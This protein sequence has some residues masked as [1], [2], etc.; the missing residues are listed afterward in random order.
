MARV[1]S[2]TITYV[3]ETPQEY[4]HVLASVHANPNASVQSNNP[5][6]RTIRVTVSNMQLGSLV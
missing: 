3:L 6:T 4:G 2:G 1:S 5:T